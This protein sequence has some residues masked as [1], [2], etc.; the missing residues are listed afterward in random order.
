MTIVDAKCKLVYGSKK[1]G[2][3]FKIL[4]PCFN[5]T[6]LLLHPN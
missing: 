2:S 4:N 1:G 3:R 6:A 5:P